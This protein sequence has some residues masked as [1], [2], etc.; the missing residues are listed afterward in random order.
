MTTFTIATDSATQTIT[1]ATADEAAAKF[2]TGE[3]WRGVSTVEQWRDHL[4]SLGGHGHI[5]DES[6]DVVRVSA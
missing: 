4:E 2:A 6:G 5:A 1:A 3:G